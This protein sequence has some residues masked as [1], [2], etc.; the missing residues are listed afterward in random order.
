MKTKVK[1]GTVFFFLLSMVL[2]LSNIYAEG[3]KSSALKKQSE[4]LHV[5]SELKAKYP[6]KSHHADLSLECVY[7]HEGQG[8]DPS[9]FEDPDETACLSCHKSKDYLAQRLAFM[10]TIKANPHNSVHDGKNLYCDEC[11]HEHEPSENMCAQCHEKEIKT[12]I[13][14]RKVP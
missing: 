4:T 13:W 9:K 8:K 3:D 7:C 6:L 14:M 1:T 12:N 11:H 2:F 5:S 10:D